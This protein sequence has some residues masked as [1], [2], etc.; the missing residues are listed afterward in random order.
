VPLLNWLR[1]LASVRDEEAYCSEFEIGTGRFPV[2]SGEDD[3][4][5]EN[6]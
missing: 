2:H 5:V 6:H 1:L 4:V 3:V